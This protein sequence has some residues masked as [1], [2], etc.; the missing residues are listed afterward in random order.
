MSKIIQSESDAKKLVDIAAKIGEILLKSGA[1]NYRVEDTA[2]RICNSRSGLTKVEAFANT[3]MLEISA[4]YD[5]N[6]IQRLVRAR[7][8]S[9]TLDLI[10]SANSFSREFCESDMSFEEAFS[11]IEKIKNTNT[12][13]TTQKSIGAGVT[14]AFFSIMFGGNLNDFFA[15]L[16]IGFLVSL[17]VLRPKKIN[18]D[19]FV[20]NLAAGFLSSLF[21]ALFMYTGLEA[22]IDMIIIGTIMPY[23]PGFAIVSSIRDTLTGDYASGLMLAA[24]AIFTA[25]AIA[26]GVGV[27]LYFYL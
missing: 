27:V 18:L 9:V 1:E 2:L 24:R 15:S 16:L 3:T 6:F 5:E 14:S 22:D 20:Q 23:V 19:S 7:E 4:I 12:F 11:K 17:I 13:T 26:S 21:A 25:I 10:D 8:P